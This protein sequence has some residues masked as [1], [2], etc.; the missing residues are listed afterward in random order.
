MNLEST[1]IHRL[2][3]RLYVL[4]LRDDHHQ[5]FSSTRSLP[6]PETW[7]RDK[8]YMLLEHDHSWHFTFTSHES[9]VIQKPCMRLMPPSIKVWWCWRQ[10][11]NLFILLDTLMKKVISVDPKYIFL[12]EKP[13]TS[14][15]EE[16]F[17]GSPLIGYEF[18]FARKPV[19]P[20]LIRVG[21]V[22]WNTVIL[23]Q[24]LSRRLFETPRCISANLE[25][26]PMKSV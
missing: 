17:L 8:H 18:L 13:I 6:S 10:V 20:T 4:V 11:S 3:D 25:L 19:T 22:R 23:L 1:M 14:S 26:L 16:H 9:R 15:R 21:D 12:K 7:P 2:L 5:A 24:C